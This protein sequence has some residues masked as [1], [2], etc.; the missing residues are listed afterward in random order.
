M[1]INQQNSP[2]QPTPIQWTWIAQRQP[3]T[4]GKGTS[5]WKCG[6]IAPDGGEVRVTFHQVGDVSGQPEPAQGGMPPAPDAFAPPGQ[7][8]T[9]QTSDATFYVTFF[10][11]RSPEFFMK[12]DISLSHEDSLTIWITITHCIIDFVQ[13]AKPGNLILDDLSNGKLKMILRSISMDT[14]AANPEYEIEQTQKHHYRTFFQVKKTGTQS[15][16]G[17]SIAGNKN[18][19]GDTQ[20][21]N[22]ASPIAS[23]GGASQ[24]QAQARQQMGD[25]GS[26][27][28]EQQ[29]ISHANAVAAEPQKPS[30][31]P[32]GNEKQED[33]NNPAF[34]SADETPIKQSATSKRG[35][36]VEIGKDYS[37]A[38]KDKSGNAIDRYR[39]KGPMDILRWL[40]E[41]GY[42]ANH[43]KIVDQEQPGNGKPQGTTA[44][45]QAESFIIEEEMPEHIWAHHNGKAFVSKAYHFHASPAHAN[46][47]HGKSI[48][49]SGEK[50]DKVKRGYIHVHHPSKTLH[51]RGYTGD[52]ADTPHWTPKDVIEKFKEQN[53]KTKDYTVKDVNAPYMKESFVV[54]GNAVMM[55]SKIEAKEAA[56]M[57]AIIN[58]VSVRLVEGEGVEFVFES[59]KDMNFKKALVELAMA[60][61]YESTRHPM[62]KTPWSHGFEFHEATPTHEIYKHPQ[63]GHE[64]HLNR[65]SQ[66]WKYKG[67]K[68]SAKGESQ[69][70]LIDHL[71]KF[72]YYED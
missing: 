43:M 10:S 12:W 22:Q 33:P 64:I 20:P 47:F 17:N 7:P 8:N 46:W 71:K 39:A 27:K 34:Q 14:V 4:D 41:K 32:Q 15:A 37:I 45:N 53:P 30:D 61:V 3:E 42:G 48:P 2:P 68:H 18:I 72:P 16:F 6:F 58:A 49:T 51:V 65:D 38:V 9:D 50:F 31:E 28:P 69:D 23:T 66:N 26:A 55:H 24:V 25:E 44:A 35:L 52:A 40:Q 21:P 19:E 67:N 36:T 57:N 59:D 70:S 62:W 63:S 54:T 29:P 1:N 5:I 60:R 13:K 11:N 56:K